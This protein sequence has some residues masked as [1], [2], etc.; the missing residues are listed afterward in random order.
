M[1][2]IHEI[3]DVMI[4]SKQF[5]SDEEQFMFKTGFD[6]LDYLNGQIT[7]ADDG[8]KICKI[9]V[10]SGKIITI[11]G[12]SGSGKSTLGIQI[13]YNI[14]KKYDQGSMIILDFESS[15][16]EERVRM[17]TG[18]SEAEYERRI[19]IKKIGISTQSVF[20]TIMAIKKLKIENQ[21]DLMVDNSEG[22]VD[23][24]G[25]LV[26][27]LPPTVILVDS[28]ALMMPEDSLDN[29]E[30]KGQMLATQ[31]AK[32]NTQ[33]FKSIIQPCMQ[34][35]IICI[36]INHINQK[37]STGPMPT[38]ASINY[39]KQDETLPG[40]NSPQYLTNT[41]IKITTG[42][43]LNEDKT[44]QIHGFE[45][46]V[47]L[48]KSRTA[49]AG[50]SVTMIYNP[51][52]GFDNELS[53][54]EYLKADG[55]LKGAGTSYFLEGLENEKF[56]LSNFKKKLKESKTLSDYFYKIGRESLENSISKSDK[57]K[58]AETKKET[59]TSNEETE[60]E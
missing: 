2:L 13:G 30:M 27:I 22:T 37:I 34:A 9:G 36:F 5:G 29:E 6:C 11:I 48:I 1:D 23:K 49:P 10:D 3:K 14:I 54:L 33:L 18:M 47:E 24:D 21:K 59:E 52:E 8:G 31:M 25:K 20:R 19:S 17:I 26:K 40:G 43:K 57:I 39:L 28:I 55:K 51:R 4:D 41:L 45:T 44:Y 42:S 32:T 35:N 38:A 7:H 46:K 56:R 16:S 60:E 53:L 12:K 58:A 15:N 50:R